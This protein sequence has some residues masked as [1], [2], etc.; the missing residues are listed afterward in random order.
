MEDGVP[1]PAAAPARI[2]AAVAR[3]LNDPRATNVFMLILVMSTMGG[4]EYA[5]GAI[6]SL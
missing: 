1:T 2:G 4:A 6:C 3:L 5:Q